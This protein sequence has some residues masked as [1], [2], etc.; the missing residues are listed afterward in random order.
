ME[1]PE[2]N[3]IQSENGK[4][5]RRDIWKTFAQFW[6][7]SN[8]NLTT[9]SSYP[10]VLD[11]HL[12]TAARDVHSF[13]DIHQEILVT[14]SYD[15]LYRRL[16]IRFKDNIDG[17]DNINEVD[18]MNQGSG[19]I[20]RPPLSSQG[21]L[22]TGQ[23]G[24]GMSFIRFLRHST[25]RSAGKSISL[26]FLVIRLLQDYP[27]EP[28]IVIQPMMTLLFYKG[29][30]FCLSGPFEH[31]DMPNPDIFTMYGTRRLCLSVVEWSRHPTTP[32]LSCPYLVNVFASS[33]GEAQSSR[34]I[35]S[36]NP[37]VWAIPT[38]TLKEL[39]EG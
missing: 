38:W 24:I 3:R 10:Y 2:L 28:L 34:F 32:M 21:V 9:V 30:T 8:R 37:F 11:T 39:R 27:Q 12:L 22:I 25:H 19:K 35:K 4:W 6:T 18:D 36:H 16:K 23:P 1:D 17:V 7:G 31:M 14:K 26:W 33:P 20:V 13:T 29:S 5:K 15:D